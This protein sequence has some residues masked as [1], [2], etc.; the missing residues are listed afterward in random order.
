MFSSSQP[1]FLPLKEH[2]LFYAG[3]ES[4]RASH[5]NTQKQELV[6]LWK[7]CYLQAEYHHGPVYEVPPSLF[8]NFHKLGLLFCYHSYEPQFLFL[9][10]SLF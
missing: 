8:L 4:T 1:V 5:G 10:V 9:F 3:W 7:R 6:G 2:G